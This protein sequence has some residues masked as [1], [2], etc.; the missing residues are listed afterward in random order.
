MQTHLGRAAR[1]AAHA[2]V[3]RVTPAGREAVL[4]DE[5]RGRRLGA[6]G[7]GGRGRVSGAGLRRRLDGDGRGAGGGGRVRD[8]LCVFAVCWYR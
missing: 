6:G 8:D 5:Q 4:V 2:A 7:G 1:V 3:A